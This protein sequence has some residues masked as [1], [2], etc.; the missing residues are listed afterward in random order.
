MSSL[1]VS[2]K[3]IESKATDKSWRHRFLHY[4]S[5]AGGGLSVAIETR[6]LIQSALKAY[7]ASPPPP[8]M[9]HI[10]FDKD[11]PTGFRDI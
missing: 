5:M 3:R 8:V 7:T 9:L 10:K 11:W 2:I 6:V 1:P 4:K